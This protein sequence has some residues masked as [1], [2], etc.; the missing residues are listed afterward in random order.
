MN[1]AVVKKIGES[2]AKGHYIVIQDVYGNQYTY[3]NLDSIAKLYPVPKAD[4]K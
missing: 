4:A 3:S 2:K 1:D